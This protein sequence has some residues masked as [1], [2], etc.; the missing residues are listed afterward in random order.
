MTAAMVEPERELARRVL[1]FA[2][3][4]LALA[5]LAGALAGGPDVGWSAT[6]G[7]A[8]VLGNFWAHA[9]SL[10][11]AA[12]ISP[13]ILFAVGL[14]GFAVR[15]GVIVAIIAVLNGLGW[16]STVAFV[17]AVVPATILLLGFEMKVIGDR[18]QGGDLWRF[19]SE[20]AS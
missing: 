11:W 2:V 6:I 4:A 19:P 7:V 3:P 12:R 17:A 20:R 10:A 16:F 18:L 8:V 13:T 1:P 15:L 5:F 9:Y 14:G